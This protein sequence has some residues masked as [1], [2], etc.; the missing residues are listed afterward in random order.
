M[1]KYIIPLTGFVFPGLPYLL[2][3]EYKKFFLIFPLLYLTF[4]IGILLKGGVISPSIY[5]SPKGFFN[6][7]AYLTFFAQMLFGLPAFISYI[8]SLFHQTIIYKGA[9]VNIT[10]PP[11]FDLGSYY[12]IVAG[13]LNYYANIKL[14]DNK[15]RHG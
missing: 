6:P 1:K 3:K 12:L 7:L 9:I 14:Y 13:S 2:A 15:L 5:Q 8:Y 10:Y 4:I 11:F